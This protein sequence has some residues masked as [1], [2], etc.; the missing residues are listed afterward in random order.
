M[1]LYAHLILNPFSFDTESL[2]DHLQETFCDFLS[3]T[4]LEESFKS[5]NIE[6]FWCALSNKYEEIQ[7]Y[8]LT[9][10]LPFPITYLADCS[11]SALVTIKNDKRNIINSKFPLMVALSE[12]E[13]RF[14][15][16]CSKV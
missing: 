16:L 8:V 3:D 4:S 5:P 10:L 12:I 2:P 15:I 1:D 13:P 11:F 9:L 14:T 6:E 7:K